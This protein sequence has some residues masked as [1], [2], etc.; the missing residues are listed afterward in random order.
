MRPM[1]PSMAMKTK[2]KVSS[3][4]SKKGEK[5]KR[6]PHGKGMSFSLISIPFPSSSQIATS[7]V[8]C[9]L[10]GEISKRHQ[11]KKRKEKRREA[12]SLL[13]FFYDSS[14]GLGSCYYR[15]GVLD[16]LA[17]AGVIM[18]LDGALRP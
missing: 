3:F 12:F 6:L 2:E 15:L 14:G 10:K 9:C 11:K 18:L 1:K 7:S 4:P 17:E 13:P 8:R 16:I 5:G